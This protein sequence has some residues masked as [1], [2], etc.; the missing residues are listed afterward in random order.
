MKHEYHGGSGQVT[1]LA[2]AAG[3][4]CAGVALA[5]VLLFAWIEGVEVET[6]P[7]R[8]AGKVEQLT[9]AELCRQQYGYVMR[10]EEKYQLLAFPLED[11]PWTLGELCEHL[12]SSC[13][14][15][16]S[17]WYRHVKPEEKCITLMHVACAHGAGVVF[18]PKVALYFDRKSGVFLRLEATDA[19]P[20]QAAQYT[21]ESM[22]NLYYSDYFCDLER[23]TEPRVHW[24][25]YRSGAVYEVK[26]AGGE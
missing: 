25:D 21:Y 1:R 15:F 12:Y 17:W 23:R 19:Q 14:S 3:R 20:T 11:R 22:P 18:Y 5:P 2:R 4:L 6:L 26:T 9:P 8:E 10:G 13:V 24:F 16:Q 7:V